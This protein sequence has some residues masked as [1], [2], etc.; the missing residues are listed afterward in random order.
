MARGSRRAPSGQG[1]LVAEWS[2]LGKFAGQSGVG[3]S[4]FACPLIKS[5]APTLLEG[6]LGGALPEGLDLGGLDIASLLDN[7]DALDLGPSSLVLTRTLD[8]NPPIVDPP[9]V[10]GSPG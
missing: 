8:E 2:Q 4:G 7:L 10:P 5:Y 6:L 3:L 9:E 1:A